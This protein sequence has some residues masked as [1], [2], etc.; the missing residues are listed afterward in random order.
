MFNFNVIKSFIMH[1]GS[2]NPCHTYF[3][4]DQPLLVV[5]EHK[6]LG[7]IIDCS[8]KFQSQTTSIANKANR[9]LGLIKNCFFNTLN[10]KTLYNTLVRPHLKYANVVW[11]PN[12][13]GD[14]DIMER[15]QKRATRCA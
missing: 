6:S 9:V 12:Y 15:V 10:Q 8:L 13:I 7:M 4:D 5:S 11:G 14:C 1:L 3:M 2:T